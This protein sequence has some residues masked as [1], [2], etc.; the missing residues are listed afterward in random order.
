MTPL[1]LI[2]DGPSPTGRG[3]LKGRSSR[4]RSAAFSF[5]LPRDLIAFR[6]DELPCLQ[7][8]RPERLADLA[9]QTAMQDHDGIP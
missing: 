1:E 5:F 4:Q 6:R 9:R 8:M 3:N 7:E 2:R